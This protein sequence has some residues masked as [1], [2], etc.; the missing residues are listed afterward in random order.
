MSAK[1]SLLPCT[2]AQFDSVME[3]LVCLFD[4]S[5]Y[6]CPIYSPKP[7]RGWKARMYMSLEPDLTPW[8]AEH[9]PPM[10]I[11]SAFKKI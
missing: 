2:R 11:R 5:F 1:P 6:F 8:G 9:V 10:G 4:K 3:E 7:L